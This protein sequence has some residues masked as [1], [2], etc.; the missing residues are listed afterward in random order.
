MRILFSILVT[1]LIYYAGLVFL[2]DDSFKKKDL[3]L[4]VA[5]SLYIPIYIFKTFLSIA[6]KHRKNT[7][8]RNKALLTMFFG[9]R[10]ALAIMIE[11]VEFGIENNYIGQKN[12]VVNKNNSVI[13]KTKEN[14]KFYNSLDDYIYC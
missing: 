8:K 14:R 12:K 11:V 5:T 2:T 7:V 13:N 6:I 3:N 1:L 9:F 10:I 4:S